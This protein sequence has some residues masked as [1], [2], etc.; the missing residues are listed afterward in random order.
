V[1]GEV[2]R[3]HCGKVIITGWDEPSNDVEI[4]SLD[5]RQIYQLRT[6]H[7]DILAVL[8]GTF[9]PLHG[10]QAWASAVRELA[11]QVRTAPLPTPMVLTGVE[12]LEHL[13]RSR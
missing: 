6:L 1:R 5:G 2:H 12:A 9:V 10:T 8:D 4:V 7:H 3:H 13:R 11:E